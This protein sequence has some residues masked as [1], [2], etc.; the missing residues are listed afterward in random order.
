MN[1]TV[2]DTFTSIDGAPD[3]SESPH[4]T[5]LSTV[6]EQT[7]AIDQL[8]AL[9]RHQIRV[10]DQDLA[11][12]GWGTSAR[13]DR[14]AEFLRGTQGRRLDVI[15]HDT[16]Y[17]ESACPRLIGL[18]RRYGHAFAIHRTGPQAKVAT[19]PLLIVDRRHYLHRFHF[20]RPR[21]SV[22]INAPEEAQLLS[23]R[24]EEIWA[25]GEVAITG[26]VLGL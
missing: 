4:V 15:V 16:R 13:I 17:I 20:E 9:A 14:L 26:T 11:Q 3:P 8:L 1:G 2:M 22:G 6:A 12:T 10:F 24:F 25:T 23:N 18:L 5:E 19:D 21:C 7:A